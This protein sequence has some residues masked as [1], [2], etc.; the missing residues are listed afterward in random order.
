MNDYFTRSVIELRNIRV[1]NKWNE[2]DLFCIWYCKLLKNC[3]FNYQACPKVF[4][5]ETIILYMVNRWL[6]E[7]LYFSAWYVNALNQ[8]NLLM[9]HKLLVIIYDSY[10]MTSER[11]RTSMAFWCRLLIRDWCLPVQGSLW[12]HNLFHY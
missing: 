7:I 12:I 5:V 2:F 4:N 1:G 11:I 9:T 3:V 8:L 10:V 6:A